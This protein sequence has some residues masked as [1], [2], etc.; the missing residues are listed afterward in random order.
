MDGNRQQSG[1]V[2]PRAN[3]LQLPRFCAAAAPRNRRRALGRVPPANHHRGIAGPGNRPPRHRDGNSSSAPQPGG[4]S[5]LNPWGIRYFRR[6]RGRGTL[7]W[8]SSEG[9]PCDAADRSQRRSIA[10]SRRFPGF[11]PAVDVEELPNCQRPTDS[12]HSVHRVGE[13]RGALSIGGL[14]AE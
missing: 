5:P 6:R 7:R 2:G 3:G 4:N 12:R 13:N 9:V 8:T 14:A 10:H 1:S 11:A